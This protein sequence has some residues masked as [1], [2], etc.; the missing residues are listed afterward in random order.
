MSVLAVI[1]TGILTVLFLWF[2]ATGIATWVMYVGARAEAGKKP[3][4]PR[5]Q[6]LN[7]QRWLDWADKKGRE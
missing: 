5:I 2:A 7:P 4:L 6:W 1:L 3:F